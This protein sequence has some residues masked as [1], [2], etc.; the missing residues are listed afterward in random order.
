VSASVGG[1]P[2]ERSKIQPRE[3]GYKVARAFAEWLT[4]VIATVGGAKNQVVRLLHWLAP[5]RVLPL[6]APAAHPAEASPTAAEATSPDSPQLGADGRARALTVISAI[7]Q[8]W[9]PY[10]TWPLRW[11]PNPDWAWPLYPLFHI[12]RKVEQ[13]H[14]NLRE[15]RFI[16]Y[17]HWSI[18]KRIPAEGGPREALRYKYL[19]FEVNFDGLMEQYVDGLTRLPQKKG[20]DT[21]R[22][23]WG[24]SFG[25]PGTLPMPDF[26]RYILRN[27]Y[28]PDYFWAAYPDATTTMVESALALSKELQRLKEAAANESV[29]D[30]EFG[31]L[32]TCVLNA[33]QLYL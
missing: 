3:P 27:A 18:V 31:A 12:Y 4:C 24:S 19:L 21:F 10:P 2:S 25:F 13:L 17:A 28:R 6:P 29:T 15:L 22:W 9:E 1:T 32:Y 16:H 11:V 14:E 30:E 20:L 5:P 23:I 26:K 33:S 7:R 8:D